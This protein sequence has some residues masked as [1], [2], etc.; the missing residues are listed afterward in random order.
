MEN[1]G[2]LEHVASGTHIVNACF[3]TTKLHREN[4][5]CNSSFDDKSDLFRVLEYL[6]KLMFDQG[7]SWNRYT[8][9]CIRMFIVW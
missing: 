5:T 2:E 9:L 6:T 1:S 3:V 7:Y 8:Y 4:I